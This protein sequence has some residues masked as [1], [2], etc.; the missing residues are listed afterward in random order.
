[1]LH[2]NINNAFLTKNTPGSLLSKKD[3]KPAKN[4]PSFNPSL[5]VSDHY[6]S[7]IS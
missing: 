7:T 4:H 3:G 5:R 1:M 6:G 2:P